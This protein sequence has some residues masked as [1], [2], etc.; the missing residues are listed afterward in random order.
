MLQEYIHLAILRSSW[1]MARFYLKENK[2]E[3]KICLDTLV[4]LFARQF[5]RYIV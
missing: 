5:T 2:T 4:V 1:A 3:K